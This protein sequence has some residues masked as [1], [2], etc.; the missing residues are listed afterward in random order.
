MKNKKKKDENLMSRS[1]AAVSCD[2]YGAVHSFLLS[3]FSILCTQKVR[4]ELK[5]P[6]E[7]PPGPRPIIRAESGPISAFFF[8]PPTYL[9]RANSLSPSKDP[10]TPSNVW[11][12]FALCLQPPGLLGGDLPL[13]SNLNLTLEETGSS[14]GSRHQGGAG[15]KRPDPWKAG[16]WQPSAANYTHLREAGGPWAPTTLCAPS[17]TSHS[18]LWEKSLGLEATRTH[19]C[20][21]CLWAEQGVRLNFLLGVL[22]KGLNLRESPGS[23]VVSRTRRSHSRHAFDP[24]SG[25]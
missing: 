2:N 22:L 1:L 14:S 24:W 4:E 23:P 15:G 10:P 11:V 13:Q 6:P 5:L 16:S 8:L 21:D 3:V 12:G 19:P 18:P 20:F 25:N 17:V 9:R 7:V